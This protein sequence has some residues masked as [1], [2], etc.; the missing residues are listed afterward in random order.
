MSKITIALDMAMCVLWI[1]TY[2]LVLI[3]T[4]RYQYPVIS[5]ITQAIIAPFEFCV[6][7]SFLRGDNAIYCNDVF[8]NG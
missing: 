1:V 8:C 7:V 2:T 4:I 3:G 5:P 6:A